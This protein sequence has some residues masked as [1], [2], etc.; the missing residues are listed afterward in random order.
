MRLSALPPFTI[1]PVPLPIW[2]ID[3]VGLVPSRPYI[4]P[5]PFSLQ[6]RLSLSLARLRMIRSL[7]RATMPAKYAP[8]R[9]ALASCLQVALS[10]GDQIAHQFTRISG[11]RTKKGRR[12]V[13]AAFTPSMIHRSSVSGPSIRGV[14][15]GLRD[16]GGR[17]R[18]APLY[19]PFQFLLWCLAIRRTFSW[20]FEAFCRVSLSF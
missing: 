15:R 9:R 18:L 20:Q 19:D 8:A 7:V 3:G 1:G 12:M 2:C 17:W 16:S 14:S 5:S 11:V 6:S 4:P 10:Y 13:F